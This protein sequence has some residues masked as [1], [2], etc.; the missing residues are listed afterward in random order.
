MAPPAP[1]WC[2]TLG[3][4]LSLSGLGSPLGNEGLESHGLYR[5]LLIGLTPQAA[6]GHTF[7]ASVSHYRGQQGPGRGHLGKSGRASS[8]FADPKSPVPG[9]VVLGGASLRLGK[10][11]LPTPPPASASASAFSP[12]ATLSLGSCHP[13]FLL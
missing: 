5:P 9:L 8:K 12:L 13:S 11:E 1:T 2:V 10:G 7:P 6:C 4:L 3:T